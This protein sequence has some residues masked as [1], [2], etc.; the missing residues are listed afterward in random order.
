MS[1]PGI[2]Y[3]TMRPNDDL[4]PAQFHE[5]YNNEHGPTRLRLPQIFAN[6][7][8]Y[9]STDSLDPPFLAA[10]DVTHMP[11]LLT[12]TYTCLRANRSPR[13]AETIGQVKVDRRFYDLVSAKSSPD[14]TPVE[15][16]SDEEAEGSVLVSVE[17]TLNNFE[18]AEAAYTEFLLGEHVD[19]LS[20]IPGWRRTRLFRTSVIEDVGE[21][22]LLALHEYSKENGLGGPE[23]LAA[24]SSPL[25]NEIFA[26]YVHSKNRRTYELFYVFG[27]GPRDLH[28]LSDLPAGTPKFVS[29]GDETPTLTTTTT[30]PGPDASIASYIQTADSLTIPYLLEGNPAPDAPVV[31]FSN[32]LLTSLHMW[33]PL[34]AIIKAQRPDLKILRYDTRGRH[35]LPQPP[36]PATVEILAGDIKALLDALRITKLHAL[37]GVSMGGATTLKFA[38]EYPSYLSRFIA[39]DF[40][41][42]SSAANTEAWKERTALAESE[43][44][45]GIEKLAGLTVGRW[46]HPATVEKKP[47]VTEWM[48]RIVAENDVEGFKYGCQ[49][50]WDYDLKPAMGGCEVPGLLV[51]GDGDAKGALVRAMEGFKGLVGAKGVELKIVPEAG[52]LPMSES[53]EA[54]WEAV[55]E[56][57]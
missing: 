10:Y 30:S 36:K 46:F 14:F 37:I 16:L 11:H 8:R 57:I 25:R 12:P 27:P 7:L 56:F 32:S 33:D 13:E 15:S 23:H 39:C 48:T 44:G 47:D 55:R 1:S 51:V 50:L 49:A 38:L 40:N 28:S 24:A 45:K 35:A 34:V 6:G 21:T 3:V 26:K 20:R 19:M 9:R 29:S 17:I 4:P 2:L 43:A 22:K 54:F 18:G 31:A 41:V 52:H 42:T 5:W 53:P